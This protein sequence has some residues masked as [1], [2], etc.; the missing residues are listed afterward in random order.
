MKRRFSKTQKTIFS[1]IV[2]IAFIFVLLCY[3]I[4]IYRMFEKEKFVNQAIQISDTNQ[5]PVFKLREIRI[6]S[7]ADAI[8]NTEEK[9]LKDLDISQYTDISIFIDNTSYIKDLTAENTIK[10]IRIDNIHLTSDQP[11]GIKSL[12]Y[13]NP[14]GLGKF[15]ISDAANVYTSADTDTQCAPIDYTAVYKN[16]ENTDYSKPTFYTD[17][18]NPITLGYLNRNIVSHYA[19]PDNDN[20]SFNGLLLKHARVDLVALNTA[21]SFNVNITNNLNQTFTYNVKINLTFD[22]NSEIVTNG[23][24]F[25]GRESS[26]SK[27]FNFFKN[28]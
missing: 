7:S 2:I 8:D 25:Q 17:C 19:L 15:V 12:T 4:M 18:S 21:I 28:I 11:T 9:S 23:Y 5:D 24:S 13:K 14:N 16:E 27:A 22:E 20:V 10:S 3:G 6:F 26:N 1:V